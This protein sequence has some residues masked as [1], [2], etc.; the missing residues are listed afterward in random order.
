MDSVESR[1]LSLRVKKS[2]S[3]VT[4][5]LTAKPISLRKLGGPKAPKRKDGKSKKI[6][7]PYSSNPL[8]LVTQLPM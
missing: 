6:P 1:A 8:P 7:A 5:K 4:Y 3:L 2:M